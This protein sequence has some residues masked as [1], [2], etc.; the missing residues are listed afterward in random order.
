[1]NQKVKPFACPCGNA[2]Y[3]DY[4]KCCGRFIDDGQVPTSATDLMRSRYTAFALRNEAYLRATWWPETLPG[5]AIAGEDDVK[6][7][8]LKV[9]GHTEA[10]D[11]RHATVEFIASFKVGGRAHKLHE[12]SNFI[13]EA[14][15]D[16]T[17]R[18]Y[19]V[20]GVFPEFD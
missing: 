2:K 5:D 15:A 17:Q 9:A 19:Y 3:P 6:W 7:I 4:T 11:A 13:R 8:A 20:D 18:W 14:H 16:G 12:I 1:M 10:P